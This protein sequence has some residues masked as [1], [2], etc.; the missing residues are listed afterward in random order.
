MLLAATAALALADKPAYKGPF[1]LKH[2]ES[3]KED[4]D[5]VDVAQEKVSEA[6]PDAPKIKINLFAGLPKKR[7]VAK[8][9]IHARPDPGHPD[10][11]L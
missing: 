4:D 2:F 7:D 3:L 10:P 5:V 11:A 6:E 9:A 8:E 1:S